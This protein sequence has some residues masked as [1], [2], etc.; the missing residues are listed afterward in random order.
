MPRIG[1]ASVRV[2]VPMSVFGGMAVIGAGGSGQSLVPL[3]SKLNDYTV[4]GGHVVVK[5]LPKVRGDSVCLR[6]R[7][8][9]VNL[10]RQFCPQL[11]A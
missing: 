3:L 2:F 1:S 5:R 10:H 6:H 11:V 9:V 4:E 7:Q 8:F